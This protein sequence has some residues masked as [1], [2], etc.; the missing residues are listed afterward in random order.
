MQPRLTSLWFFFFSFLFFVFF[1][2][3][4]FTCCP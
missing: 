4:M 1:F 3:N 2:L